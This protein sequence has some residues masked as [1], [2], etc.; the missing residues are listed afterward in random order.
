MKILK[1]FFLLAGFPI[2]A[3]AGPCGD[4]GAIPPCP[5]ACDA[6][7]QKVLKVQ[8]NIIN[9]NTRGKDY[10]TCLL[11]RDGKPADFAFCENKYLL[12]IGVPAAGFNNAMTQLCNDEEEVLVAYDN[13]SCNRAKPIDPIAPIVHLR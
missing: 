1:I 2:I 10:L 9:L 8:E 4:S 7:L 12:P 6:P 11:N 5:G 13:M 3:L